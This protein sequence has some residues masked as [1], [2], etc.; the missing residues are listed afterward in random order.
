MSVND[1][2]SHQADDRQIEQG[3]SRLTY[4]AWFLAGLASAIAVGSVALIV[5]AKADGGMWFN[6]YA[7]DRGAPFSQFRFKLKLGPFDEPYDCYAVGT[8][9]VNELNRVN[10]TKDFKG[11]CKDGELFDLFQLNDRAKALAPPDDRPVKGTAR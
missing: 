4:I 3:L 7:A 6:L 1:P 11:G 8:L 5:S 2:A 10:P 9:G